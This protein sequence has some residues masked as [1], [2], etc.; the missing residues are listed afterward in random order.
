MALAQTELVAFL[1]A[2]DLW[3]RLKLEKQIHCFQTTPQL[4]FCISQVQNFWSPELPEEVRAETPGL[5]EPWTGHTSSALVA[6]RSAF[7]SVGLLNTSMP[8]GEDIDWFV[9]AAQAKIPCEIVPEVLTYRRL[10]PGNLSRRLSKE[11]TDAMLRT[12][13]HLLDWK[14]NE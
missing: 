5:F 8:V 10:H 11:T 12:V 4:Q 3:H 1:D 9:R 7:D 14:R 2:D 6:K 13:K